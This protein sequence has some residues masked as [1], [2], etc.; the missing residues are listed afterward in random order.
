MSEAVNQ[1]LRPRLFKL[2]PGTRVVSH[3]FDMGHWVPDVKRTVAVP[4]KPYG[5]PRSELLM[6]IVPADFSGT[7]SWQLREDGAVHDVRVT[8][9]QKFQQLEGKA[10]TNGGRQAIGQTE[11]RGDALR[12]VLEANVAGK[13]VRQE[14]RG[15]LSGDTITG[16]AVTIGGADKTITGGARQRWRATRSRRGV[17]DIEAGAQPYTSGNFNK[18]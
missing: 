15:R 3:D 11:V 7:W 6:W 9:A 13:V 18:E 17:F 14:Y 2:R 1:R 4:D 10:D 8:F 16:T 5:A 12:F